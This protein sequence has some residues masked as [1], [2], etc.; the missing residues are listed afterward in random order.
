MEGVEDKVGRLILHMV[1][2]EVLVVLLESKVVVVKLLVDR[3]EGMEVRLILVK[4][5]V[6]G[7]ILELQQRR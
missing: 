1:G 6:E 2:L 7:F 4:E 5:V 3:A